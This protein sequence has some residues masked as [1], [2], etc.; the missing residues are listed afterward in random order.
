MHRKIK[1]YFLSLFH[2]LFYKCFQRHRMNML[3]VAGIESANTSSVKAPAL[4]SSPLPK[5]TL[6]SFLIMS[7]QPML[8]RSATLASFL[9]MCASTNV[10]KV[11]VSSPTS[12]V[13]H[14]V[15]QLRIC[16]GCGLS[17]FANSLRFVERDLFLLI[18]GCRDK[19][20]AQT[21]L[22]TS[23]NDCA[24]ILSNMLDSWFCSFC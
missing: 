15:H 2:A 9:M 14:R 11:T 12:T 16:G 17:H 5:V 19:L 8:A 21:A 10:F 1:V 20:K 24:S 3:L 18:L 13:C 6:T 22:V 4:L 7:S 23:L